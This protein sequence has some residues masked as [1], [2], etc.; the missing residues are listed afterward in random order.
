MVNTSTPKTIKH[1]KIM[2]QETKEGQN[3]KKKELED[4]IL[5]GKFPLF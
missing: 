4:L 2:Q 1:Y 3:K 5:R